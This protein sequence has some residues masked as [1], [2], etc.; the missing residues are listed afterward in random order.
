[1]LKYLI[2][3]VAVTGYS[4]LLFNKG[5]STAENEFAVQAA[6]QVRETVVANKALHDYISKLDDKHTK[7]LFDAQDN[8]SNILDTVSTGQRRLFVTTV[9]AKCAMPNNSTAASVDHAATRAELNKEF[10]QRIIA[11]TARGDKAIIQLNACQDYVKAVA[12]F[13]NHPADLITEMKDA[14]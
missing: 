6:Q 11:I 4:W 5:Y 9:K 7:E 1:M 14:E 13:A 2:I 12:G 8:V 3:L 10:A